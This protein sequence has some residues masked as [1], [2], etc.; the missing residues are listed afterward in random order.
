VR[1]IKKQDGGCDEGGEGVE[2]SG[3]KGGV[4]KDTVLLLKSFV[5]LPLFIVVLQAGWRHDLDVFEVALL[6]GGHNLSL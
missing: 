6:S 3:A 2:G 5:D 4:G 1:D